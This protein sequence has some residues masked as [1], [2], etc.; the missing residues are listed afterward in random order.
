MAGKKKPPKSRPER[1][2]HSVIVIF[3]LREVF[4]ISSPASVP[5]LRLIAAT[6]DVRHLQK[7]VL[8]YSAKNPANDVESLVREGENTY[9]IRMLCGHLYEAGNA[10][11]HLDGQCKKQVDELIKH[12]PEAVKLIK[13]LRHIYSDNSD[14]GLWKGLDK[15][16][17]QV[18][19][20]YPETAFAESLK[21]HPD[22]AK[23]ALV[24]YSGMGRYSATDTIMKTIAIRALGG[25]REDFQNKV[26]EA[27]S[28]AGLL[29]QTV[30]LLIGALFEKYETA[31]LER[32]RGMVKVPNYLVAFEE[33]ALKGGYAL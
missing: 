28:L 24:Q 12:D 20:H 23:F 10:L 22:D 27:I 1:T 16:R 4:P 21:D 9:L 6:N 29:A 5:F 11:H 2:I 25:S 33:S 8:S 3:K 18:S 17:N 15:M 30:D 19:F 7:L 14:G 26:G 31:I 32:K 13:K